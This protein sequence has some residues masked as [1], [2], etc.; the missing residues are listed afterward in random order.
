MIGAGPV[1][2]SECPLL[3]GAVL[4]G[5]EEA[6]AIEVSVAPRTALAVAEA[7]ITALRVV[8]GGGLAVRRLQE[9]V[10]LPI[11][12]NLDIGFIRKE[13]F[14]EMGTGAGAGVGMRTWRL[15]DSSDESD[16]EADAVEETG[17][18]EDG[19][20]WSSDVPPPGT[21]RNDG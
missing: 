5:G 14:C 16:E 21:V 12:C 8:N 15:C 7:P 3:S 11:P 18:E 1:V 6:V 19:V 9:G 4:F 17:T 20:G 2:G 10:V 13:G